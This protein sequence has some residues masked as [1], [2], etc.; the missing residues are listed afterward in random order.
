MRLERAEVALLDGR[1]VGLRFQDAAGQEEFLGQLL[2]PLLA[3]VG[4]RDDQN[5]PLALRPFLRE[6]QAR[7]D[8]LAQA[9]F[10]RQQ[11]AL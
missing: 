9:D 8:G 11:R 5:A 6:H 4:R 7:L 10:V 1:V 3:E 2:M